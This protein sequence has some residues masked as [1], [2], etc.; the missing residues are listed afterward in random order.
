MNEKG[1]NRYVQTISQIFF[2]EI[3]TRLIYLLSFAS[4]KIDVK[5]EKIFPFSLQWLEFTTIGLLPVVAAWYGNNCTACLFLPCYS[6][7]MYGA[8]DCTDSE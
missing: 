3:H 6:Y 8:R 5:R 2:D 1:G 7:S 4:K